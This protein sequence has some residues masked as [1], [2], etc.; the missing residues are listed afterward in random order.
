[1]GEDGVTS[2]QKGLKESKGT[3]ARVVTP[4]NPTEPAGGDLPGSRKGGP[5]TDAYLLGDFREGA[6]RVKRG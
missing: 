2:K 6:A 1:M 4:R 3:I 5:E